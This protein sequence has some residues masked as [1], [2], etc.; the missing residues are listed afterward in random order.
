MVETSRSWW[1]GKL[2]IIPTTFCLLICIAL[3]GCEGGR[4]AQPQP[5]PATAVRSDAK[6]LDLGKLIA[7]ALRHG[8]PMPPKGAR[9][10]LA[11]TGSWLVLGNRSSSRDPAIY[12][13]AYLLKENQDRGIVVLC[14]TETETLEW[15]GEILWRPFSTAEVK[16]KLG[17]YAVDFGPLSAF[18]CA[19][20]TAAAGDEQTAQGIWDRFKT[21]EPLEYDDI[22]CGLVDYSSLEN[23]VVQMLKD[24][25]TLLARC[26]FNHLENALLQ[27][28]A[29]WREIHAKMTAL[30]KEFPSL[31]EEG[32]RELCEDLDAAVNSK[33]APPGSIE[34]LLIEWSRRP[35][36][37]GYLEIFDEWPSSG[38][39]K[40]A[41]KIVLQGFDAVPGLLAL[42]EDRRL[43]VH[44]ER[45]S[46][47]MPKRQL[48][49]GEL[50]ANLLQ[51][52]AGDVDLS[53]SDASE[54]AALR[55]WWE[56]AQVRN[57]ADC[58]AEA[59][60]RREGGRIVWVNDT[61]AHILATKY[62]EKLPA[63]CGEFSE[64]ATPDAQPFAL[65]EAI[66]SSK[67]PKEVRV[68][69]LS[70]FAQ[71]G[72]L[73]HRRCVL[74]N[75]AKLDGQAC[76][77]ILLPLLRSVPNDSHGPHWTSPEASLTHVVME[78]EDDAVW[79]EYLRLAKRCSVGLRME[80]MNS[81]DYS[82]I[83]EKNRGRRLAFLASFLD[84][85]AVR[86]IPRDNEGQFEGP[87][88]AFTI[89]RIRVRDFAAMQIASILDLDERPDEFWGRA[90]WQKLREK[91]RKKLA[92]EK[93]PVF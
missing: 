2:R 58:L 24:P 18:V 73:E 33:P 1:S 91:V 57:E 26:I 51:E 45:A 54:P 48:R 74:Q 14:G 80:M 27:D 15:R 4:T 85:D 71:R 25:H 90:H 29:K 37:A 16:P 40:P 79:R 77:G 92:A 13:P 7:I 41:R 67:L 10:V 59:V 36:G 83:G 43:T 93:L 28:Q 6:A 19:V 46:G 84:D 87:C 76:S 70:D 55:A 78:L 21:L 53:Q 38:D 88:A 17:G 9:L 11:N 3:A 69:V 81:M 86:K 8:L 39:D 23:S 75:L 31:N 47:R 63:L 60:F 65:A 66:V 32:R 34:S 42:V 61:P 82:Y 64:H 30:L 5:G 56:Q 20:Q 52:I 68:R 44:V 62:P 50:A 35:G 22:T 72:S 89:P 49:V 12:S